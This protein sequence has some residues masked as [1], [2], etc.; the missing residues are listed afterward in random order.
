MAVENPKVK[1]IT[2]GHDEKAWDEGLA[3]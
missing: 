1:N 3:P 2:L